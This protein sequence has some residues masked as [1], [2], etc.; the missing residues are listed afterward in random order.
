MRAYRKLTRFDA[1]RFEEHLLRLDAEQRRLRFAGSQSDH[2]IRSHCA[3]RQWPRDVVIGF[4]DD[5]ELRGAAE[6]GFSDSTSA[7]LAEV[8]VTVEG[9]WQNQG[10]GTEL[11]RQAILVARNRLVGTLYLVCLLENGAMYSVARKFVPLLELRQGFA[12]ARILAPFPTPLSLWEEAA[13]HG[14]GYFSTE[15]DSLIANSNVAGNG[16]PA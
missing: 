5:N 7:T 1:H 6:I 4:F 15:F 16:I 11:L 2:A 8:A 12:E 9:D 3:N 13:I 10:I 14:L